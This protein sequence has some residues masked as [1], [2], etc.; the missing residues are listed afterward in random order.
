M[1]LTTK[2]FSASQIG[3]PPKNPEMAELF[4]H[5]GDPLVA[6]KLDAEVRAQIVCWRWATESMTMDAPFEPHCSALLGIPRP[7]WLKAGKES[8]ED[9]TL[10][11]LDASGKIVF[12]SSGLD[13]TLWVHEENKSTRF[14]FR[15]NSHDVTPWAG[16]LSDIWQYIF[17]ADGNLCLN[18]CYFSYRDTYRDSRYLWEND[19]LVASL[20]VNFSGGEEDSRYGH[21][22]EYDDKGDLDLIRLHYLDK[23][24]VP[25]GN[26][27][28]EYRRPK[29]GETVPVLA[30]AITEKLVKL[31]PER[32][33]EAALTEKMYALLLCYTQE[34]FSA[35][36][37]PFLVWGK[38]SWRS[39]VAAEPGY[40]LWAPDE[41]RG[42][43]SENECWLDD[44]ELV[45]LCQRHK[46]LMSDQGNYASGKKVLLDVA[47]RLNTFDWQAI[48]PVTDDF[49]VVAV[50][51]S[52]CVDAHK[53]IK[54][55]LSPEAFALL[56][57][58]GLLE[59]S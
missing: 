11:G 4:R 48:A 8:P 26:A 44:E 3:V 5:Y 13:E 12:E 47:R 42:A 59:L 7:R 32:V 1:H 45:N 6:G 53:D 28:V 10:H 24:N 40:Y 36:W 38:V 58:S 39:S 57:S 23:D 31:I 22:F 19:R 9:H 20:T 56:K 55:S 54:A 37:P 46:M 25:D 35:A 34:D 17:A 18:H 16:E 15:K 21:A 51:N 30:A 14:G 49:V 43:S 2:P 50:D 41:I 33:K 27:R 29:K 52:L